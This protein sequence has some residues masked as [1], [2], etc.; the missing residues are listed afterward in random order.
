MTP[1]ASPATSEA[2]AHPST[3][4]RPSAVVGGRL[5]VLGVAE[6]KGKL[7]DTINLQNFENALMI[8]LSFKKFF[9]EKNQQ[10]TL[11]THT[12]L[13]EQVGYIAITLI[14]LLKISAVGR[15]PLKD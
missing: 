2:V 1:S 6:R 15:F 10:K 5:F 12:T 11:P 13:K 4:Q 9:P 8:T 3:S 7:I 14:E